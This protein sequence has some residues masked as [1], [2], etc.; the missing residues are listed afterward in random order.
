MEFK[1]LSP[2]LPCID[3]YKSAYKTE[4]PKAEKKLAEVGKLKSLDREA[5]F[6][7]LVRLM[8]SLLTTPVSDADIQRSFSILRKIH[9]DQR[10]SLSQETLIA[11]V[12]NKFNSLQSCYEAI[13]SRN[14][15]F[16]HPINYPRS[17]GT[18]RRKS[19]TSCRFCSIILPYWL[20]TL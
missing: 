12:A 3:K 13:I 18:I 20:P 8:T 19:S 2:D 4:R 7:L 1:L 9:S 10:P 14:S 5:R 6:P 17:S 11:L 16:S 15:S